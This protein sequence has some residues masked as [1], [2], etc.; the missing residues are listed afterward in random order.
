STADKIHNL[1]DMLDEHEKVGNKLWQRFNA[2]KD[3]ELWFYKTFLEIIQKK[4][5]PEKMKADL[6]L[7]VDK[8]E[9]A[10]KQG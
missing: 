8:L 1:T 9:S 10:V 5:I 3:D 7:L 4:A 2:S 6:G